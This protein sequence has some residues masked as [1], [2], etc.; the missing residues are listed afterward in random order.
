MT[1]VDKKRPAVKQ[2]AV[3]KALRNILI[4][5][6]DLSVGRTRPVIGHC[7]MAVWR[8]DS[9]TKWLPLQSPGEAFGFLHQKVQMLPRWS[10][11][12]CSNRIQFSRPTSPASSENLAQ[13]F[14]SMS[15][16]RK[17]PSNVRPSFCKA[18]L[19]SEISN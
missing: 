11:F 10:E 13:Y 7:N 15:E 19:M 6:L 2:L 9:R 14:A 16:A 17:K 3:S 1:S 4:P 5:P 12:S 18:S 8:K